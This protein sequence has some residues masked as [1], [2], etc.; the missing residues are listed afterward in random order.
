MKIYFSWITVERYYK[1][2]WIGDCWRQNKENNT[3]KQTDIP[4]TIII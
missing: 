4:N 3:E 2:T 1:R